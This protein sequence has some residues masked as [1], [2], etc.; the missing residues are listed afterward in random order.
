MGTISIYF[1]QDE[2]INNSF[3]SISDLYLKD[4]RLT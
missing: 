3:D 1:L 2:Q 4:G